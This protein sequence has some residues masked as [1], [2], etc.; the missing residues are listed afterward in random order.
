MRTAINN[1]L[2]LERQKHA[3][4]FQLTA[5]VKLGPSFLV[6]GYLSIDLRLLL[7]L[8]LRNVL[9]HNLGL[10]NHLY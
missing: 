10:I 9:G 8:V 5:Q 1:S 6:S 2:A 3:P 4:T 7:K